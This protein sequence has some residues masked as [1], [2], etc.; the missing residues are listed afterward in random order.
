MNIEIITPAPRHSRL[1]NRITADRYA[2]LLRALKHTV[3]VTT[4]YS[5]AKRDV[6]FAL[7]ARRMAKAIRAV[8]GSAPLVLVLTG[9]DV[10][11]DIHEDA[12]ARQSLD[13]AD[14]IV[15]LQALA[16]HQLPARHRGKARAIPQSTRAPK[17]LPGKSKRAL[18]MCVVGHLRPE[19]DP[20]RAAAAARLL[21]A[22]SRIRIAQA[23]GILDNRYRDEV[24]KEEAANPR[25]RYIGEL[26]HAKV[27]RLIA[28]SHA[29][30]LTSRMEGGANVIGEAC[31][32]DT[33][34]L[35]SNIDGSRGLLGD[36]YPGYFEFGDTAAL[37]GLMERFER[38]AGFRREL[39]RRCKALKPAFRPQAERDA[40]ARLLRNLMKP[41][42]T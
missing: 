7:H 22:D 27:M 36:D 6:I 29:L 34:V 17:P 1:G 3:T 10:Y 30:V 28:R 14:A 35:S 32:C 20:L 38:D 40:L 26:P 37:A 21:P 24:G 31:V 39:Q 9:T 18:D 2:G 13:A 15:T 23:G 16:I 5:G 11:R 41:G 33:P 25:Y 12:V 19:K 42:S 8:N 4:G